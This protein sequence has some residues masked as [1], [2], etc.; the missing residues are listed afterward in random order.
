MATMIETNELRFAYPAEEGET[1]VLALDGVDVQIEKGD[2][3]STIEGVGEEE[4]SPYS[5]KKIS[6]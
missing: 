1:P 6:S 4:Y 3:L 5:L 2:Y